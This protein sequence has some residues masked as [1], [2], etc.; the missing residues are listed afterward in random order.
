MLHQKAEFLNGLRSLESMVQCKILILK[1]SRTLIPVGRWVLGQKETSMQYGTQSD[2]V[3]RNRFDDAV[4][5]WGS[6]SRGSLRRVLKADLHL[7]PYQI[8]IKQMLTEADMAKRVTMCEWFCD[9][10]EDNPDFL[11]H[12]WF[13]DETHFL[14]S[15]HVNSKNN[16]YWGTAPPEEV[17]Q[18][19]LHSIKCTAWVAISKHGIIGPYWFEDEN[20][21]AQTVNTERYVAVLRKFWTS[22]GR[23]RWIYRD[24]QWF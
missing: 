11:D 5:N 4:K 18:R 10:I 15:G 9:T 1:A 13:S 14:L 23:R 19:P 21:R 12:V 17:L 16:V 7:Y 2:I 6:R 24:D 3:Q 22:L 20:E 8:Q